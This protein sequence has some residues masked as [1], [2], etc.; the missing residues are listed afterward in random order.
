MGKRGVTIIEISMVVAIIGTLAVLSLPFYS[1]LIGNNDLDLAVMVFDNS[2]QRAK[3]L[4]S[5]S[6]QDSQWGVRAA[7]GA[8]TIFK[9]SSYA[10]RDSSYDEVINLAEGLVVSGS[11]EFVFSKY[12]AELTTGGTTTFTAGNQKSKTL[13]VNVK[14]LVE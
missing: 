9:G 2:L 6:F 5:G 8:I 14:G 11:Q 12:E 1:D 10:S 4:A 13:N 3:V 7:A